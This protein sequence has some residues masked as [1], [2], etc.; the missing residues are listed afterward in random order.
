MCRLMWNERFTFSYNFRI[1]KSNQF[2]LIYFSLFLYYYFRFRF[3]RRLAWWTYFKNYFPVSLVKT[4]DLPADKSYLFATYPHGV[5]CAGSFSNFA[6]D[7]GEFSELFPGLKPHLTTLN[8]HFIMPFTRE[9][10]IGLCEYLF[11]HIKQ[12]YSIVF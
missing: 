5:L 7:A 9:I 6:T 10:G 8:L 11:K 1:V 2:I 4:H 12:M 3:M